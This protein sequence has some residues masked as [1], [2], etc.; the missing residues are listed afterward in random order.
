MDNIIKDAEQFVA[1]LWKMERDEAETK[2]APPCAEAME[3]E[4]N[5]LED[6]ITSYL[7]E[8]DDAVIIGLRFRAIIVCRMIGATV[9]LWKVRGCAEGHCGDPLCRGNHYMSLMFLV[10]KENNGSYVILENEKI[11]DRTEE[12]LSCPE[13]SGSARVIPLSL[14]DLANLLKDKINGGDDDPLP[15]AAIVGPSA[16]PLRRAW[17]KL[18]GR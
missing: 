1:E 11:M 17:Q 6:A 15:P 7:K 2:G 14:D 5:A 12:N 9:P 10:T 18:W 13:D 16:R 4:V 3:D 8:A